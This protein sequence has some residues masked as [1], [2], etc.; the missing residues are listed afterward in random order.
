MGKP[1]K[2]QNKVKYSWPEIRHMARNLL[3]SRCD[4]PPQGDFTQ[5]FRMARIK[6]GQAGRLRSPKLRPL[7][8]K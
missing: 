7:L 2:Q 4:Q 6:N 3:Y 1:Q 5:D 8:K